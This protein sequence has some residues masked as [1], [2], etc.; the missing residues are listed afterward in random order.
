MTKMT[1]IADEEMLKT[2]VD[3]PAEYE[4]MEEPANLE[5]SRDHK[6]WPALREALRTVYDPEIPVNI[7]ELGLIYKVDIKTKEGTAQDGPKYDVYV[8]MT[9]TSPGCPVAQEMPQWVQAA[10]FEVEG[11]E[12]AEVE[13]IWDPI[14]DPSM[15]S[16]TAKLMLNM[17]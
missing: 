7:Y 17:Y 15:M 8:Q 11:V 5:A 16:E 13:I 10:V 3:S 2:A 6:L 9:L 1:Q 4:E 14:W 12:D